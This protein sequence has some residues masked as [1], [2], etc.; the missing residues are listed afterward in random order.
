MHIILQSNVY[1]LLYQPYSTQRLYKMLLLAATTTTS[2]ATAAYTI[3][4]YYFQF[5]FSLPT[6]PAL[7]QVMVGSTCV[8]CCSKYFY[9]WFPLRHYPKIP[10]P[11]LAAYCPHL[12]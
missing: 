6:F 1:I 5:L 4:Y 12:N 11:I 7:I 3:Y 2:T 8:D 10:K 9:I